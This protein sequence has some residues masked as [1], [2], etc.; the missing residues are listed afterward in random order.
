MRLRQLI[1]VLLLLTSCV[2]VF[3][4]FFRREPVRPGRTSMDTNQTVVNAQIVS[5]YLIVTAK[6]DKRGPYNFLI[7]TGASTTLVS[8]MLAQ[9]YGKPNRGHAMAEGGVSV[10]SSDGETTVLEQTSIPMIT[11]GDAQFENVPALIYDCTTISVHLGLRIDGIL[12]F[13]FFR[14]LILSLDYPKSRLVLTKPSSANALQPGVTVPFNNSLGTPTIPLQLEDKSFI[15]LIDSGNDCALRINPLGMDLWYSQAPRKG[16]MVSSLTG[17]RPQIL[18]RL[19]Q[20]ILLGDYRFETPVVEIT[21]ELPALGGALLRNFVISFDQG[22]NKVTFF[23]ETREPLQFKSKRSTGISVAKAGAYWRIIGI[24]ADSPA[25]KSGV[26]EGD[27]I[28]RINSESVENWGPERFAS[29][30]EKN[31]EIVFSFLVG[32]REYEIKLRVMELVP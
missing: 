25:K 2:D 4:G 5:N 10:R 26:E 23:R 9:R 20:S 14:E 8:P 15:A 18:A 22:S 24:I 32:K 19:E 21:D 17:D 3:A 27:L 7:D 11:L 29:L 31:D 12:G 13:P 16:N 30:V 1:V 6:W 28:T